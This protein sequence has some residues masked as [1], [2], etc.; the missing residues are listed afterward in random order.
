MIIVSICFIDAGLHIIARHCQH[1]FL[2]EII[3]S[4]FDMDPSEEFMP[5]DSDDSSIQIL[6]QHS[7]VIVD[8]VYPLTHDEAFGYPI[9]DIEPDS[10]PVDEPMTLTFDTLAKLTQIPSPTVLSTFATPSVVPPREDDH[11][12]S[13]LRETFPSGAARDRAT[14]QQ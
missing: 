3:D 13:D 9:Y 8:L 10:H 14:D 1:L 6:P 11:M 5:I 7:L 4:S 12:T 2:R